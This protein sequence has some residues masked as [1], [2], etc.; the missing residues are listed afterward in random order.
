VT[1]QE[2]QTFFRNPIEGLLRR[3]L[4]INLRDDYL[5]VPDREPVELDALESYKVGAPALALLLDH[6]SPAEAQRLLQATGQLP[7]GALGQLEFERCLRSAA[8]LAELVQEHTGSARRPDCNFSLDIGTYQLRGTLDQLY[9]DGRVIH[10]FSRLRATHHL[11]FWIVHLA[12]CAVQPQGVALHSVQVGRALG[13][14]A[15]CARFSP[16]AEPLPLLASL[17]Q[18]YELGQQFPLPLFPDPSFTYAQNVARK[19]DPSAALRKAATLWAAELKRDPALLKVYGADA[20]L[21]PHGPTE[22]ESPPNLG[23]SELATGVFFPLLA[24]LGGDTE[25]GQDE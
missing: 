5:E 17:L 10:H 2:L 16:V 25:V 19:P 1:L 3:R 13:D 20:E 23:F 14:G 21:E 9:A 11:R 12:L 24:H 18:L 22:S 7:Y 6:H 4:K 8:P 15:T